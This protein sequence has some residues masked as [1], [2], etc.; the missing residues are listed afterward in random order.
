[1]TEEGNGIQ[2]EALHELMNRAEKE[3]IDVMPTQDGGR[4]LSDGKVREDS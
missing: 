4:L 2:L 1:V 3:P